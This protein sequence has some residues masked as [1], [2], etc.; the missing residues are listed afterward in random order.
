MVISSRRISSYSSRLNSLEKNLAKN[1]LTSLNVL[2]IS[3]R[4]DD[5]AKGSLRIQREAQNVFF[6]ASAKNI[7]A[8]T[9]ALFGKV[10]KVE[11]NRIHD[12][13][14]LFTNIHQLAL[15]IDLLSINFFIAAPNEIENLLTEFD[16]EMQKIK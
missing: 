1:S 11:E 12:D 9:K 15:Q 2:G 8:S 3:D 16:F 13:E 7:S 14:D 4:L 10:Q 5:V 6:K